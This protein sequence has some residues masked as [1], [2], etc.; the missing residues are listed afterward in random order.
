[1]FLSKQ[2][3]ELRSR[4]TIPNERAEIL[5][6]TIRRK[7]KSRL[8]LQDVRQTPKAAADLPKNLPPIKR[9][10]KSTARLATQRTSFRQPRSTRSNSHFGRLGGSL[11]LILA[12]S[13][14]SRVNSPDEFVRVFST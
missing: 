9:P 3:F 5:W 14:C 12:T 11:S 13:R 6:G 10:L 4:N 7:S 2:S 1:L 8:Q